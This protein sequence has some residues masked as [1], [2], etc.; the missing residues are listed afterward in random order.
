MGRKK[1]RPLR[2]AAAQAIG[3]VG[4]ERAFM[5][6]STHAEGGDAAVSRVCKEL[7]LQVESDS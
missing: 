6:L 1:A 5:A 7:L 3:K 4:G 2:I